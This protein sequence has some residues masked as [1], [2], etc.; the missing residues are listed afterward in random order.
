MGRAA[1][2]TT[3]A[4]FAELWLELK[5]L[6]RLHRGVHRVEPAEQRQAV[7]RVIKKKEIALMRKL[8]R[9]LHVEE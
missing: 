8:M 6:C 4:D 2:P 1:E 9:A 3:A 7:E 5:E